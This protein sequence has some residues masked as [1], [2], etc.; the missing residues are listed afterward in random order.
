MLALETTMSFL[1]R[2]VEKALKKNTH[3]RNKS[4]DMCPSK[5]KDV[6]SMQEM[7]AF[8]YACI[9]VQT[10]FVNMLPYLT[11]RDS[12]RLAAANKEINYQ[13]N[14]FFFKSNIWK[15]K[16]I[17]PAIG[18]EVIWQR[19]INCS[20]RKKSESTKSYIIFESL[21]NED[22]AGWRSCGNIMECIGPTGIKD[23]LEISRIGQV[24]RLPRPIQ[25][26]YEWTICAWTFF[27]N[28]LPHRPGFEQSE[29][30]IKGEHA[31]VSSSRDDQHVFYSE[32]R[33]C[34]LGCFDEQVVVNFDLQY[35]ENLDVDGFFSSA[36][37]FKHISNGWHHIAAVGSKWRLG[38]GWNAQPCNGN[39]STRYYMD[40]EHVGSV[41]YNLT[42]GV[43]YIG[44]VSGSHVD[45]NY[46]EEGI[47]TQPWGI[48]ADFRIY[49]RGL[50]EK[51]IKLLLV[52]PSQNNN[53]E[54]M[55][56]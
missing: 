27:Y 6:Y 53:V 36:F 41:P 43:Q 5:D 14:D 35:S 23:A 9:N 42:T 28:G 46:S 3:S 20:T 21:V 44:N 38:M 19:A 45:N 32:G 4:S 52:Q 40:G 24:V 51:E 25:I 29:D 39:G 13:V 54:N 37:S 30:W 33:G 56:F 1:L 17:Y 7:N 34:W 31:L 10:V 55:S 50:S 8:E 11:L 18:D 16:H 15:R 47:P 22:I 2:K 12:F 26:G 48:I 49:R